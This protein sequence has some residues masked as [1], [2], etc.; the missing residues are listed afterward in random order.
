MPYH[1]EKGPI[2]AA[3]E[4]LYNDRVRLEAFLHELWQGK[5]LGTLGV[6]TSPS[7]DSPNPGDANATPSKRLNSLLTKWFGELDGPGTDQRQFGY[8]TQADRLTLTTGYWKQYY[9]DVRGIVAET[10][11]RAAEVSLG[12]DKPDPVTAPAYTRHWPVEFFWKCGQPRFEGWV[13]WR[14]DPQTGN[15][16]VTVVFATPPTPDTVLT[17]P[18]DG[19]TEV[20]TGAM[21]NWQGMWVCTHENHIQYVLPT[22]EPSPSGQWFAPTYAVMLTR[23][24]GRVGTWAPSFGNG[25]PPPGGPVQFQLGATGG[26]T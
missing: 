8:D 19:G 21:G 10:L 13:T 2:F 12:V 1:L 18:R 17:R 16:H 23:G 9:G 6:I 5:R 14:Q 22:F 4:A 26:N 24:V 20:T 25:G 7:M 11:R 3:F 15:G